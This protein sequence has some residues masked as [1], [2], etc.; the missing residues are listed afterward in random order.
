MQFVPVHHVAGW[1]AKGTM[2]GQSMALVHHEESHDC[3]NGQCR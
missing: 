1:I 3:V 2:D